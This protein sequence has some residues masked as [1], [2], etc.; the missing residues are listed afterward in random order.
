MKH[1]ELENC[2]E[3]C[4]NNK[5]KKLKKAINI[6]DM[7]KKKIMKKEIMIGGNDD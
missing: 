4:A 6:R 3:I 7:F 1:N 5:K 2:C